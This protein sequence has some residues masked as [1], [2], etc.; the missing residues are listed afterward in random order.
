MEKHYLK[1]NPK[2]DQQTCLKENNLS[3]Q[4]TIIKQAQETQQ[5]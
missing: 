5:Q 4:N 2:V 1:P 3:E